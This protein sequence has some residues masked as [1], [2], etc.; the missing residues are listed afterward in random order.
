MFY[1]L[2]VDEAGDVSCSKERCPWRCAVS[3]S[4]LLV[5]ARAS[6]SMK[7]LIIEVLNHELSRGFY[8]FWEITWTGP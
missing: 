8:R 1:L 2:C 5:L 7:D 4:Q 3:R 6:D